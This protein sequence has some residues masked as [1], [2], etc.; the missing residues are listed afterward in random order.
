M[1]MD[2][3][4]SLVDLLTVAACVHRD[5]RVLHANGAFLGALGHSTLEE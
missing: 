3:L 5:G 2:P 4:R 1:S